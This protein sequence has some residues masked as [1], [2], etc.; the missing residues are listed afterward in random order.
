MNLILAAVLATTLHYDLDATFVRDEGRFTNHLTITFPAGT[1]TTPLLLGGAYEVTL[2]DALNGSVDIAP[3]D[4]PWRGLQ[5]IAITPRDPA[6]AVKLHLRYGGKLGPSGTPPLNTISHDL[7]ELN[8]DSMWIPVAEGF[9]TRFT[10]DANLRGIPRQLI[11]VAP[12]RVTQTRDRITIRRDVSDFDVSF[13]AMRGMRRTAANGFELYAL[14]LDSDV[15]GDLVKLYRQHGAA[16]LRF[17]ES[18][19]GAMPG[20][21]A[22]VV[23]VRRERKSGY[24]RRG[25]IVVTEVPRPGG[26]AGNAKFIAHEFAHAWWSPVD[27]NT[28]HRWLQESLAEYVALRYIEQSLG[29]PALESL[30]VAKRETAKTATPL[31][32]RGART[33]RE[34]YDKGPL[35]LMELEQRIGRASLDR[36]LRNLAPHPPSVTEEFMTELARVAGEEHAR[37]FES[38]LRAD[39]AP[40]PP[41]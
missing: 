7:V 23:V 2:A 40:R 17:L 11:A 25:Y 41:S 5:R 36:V 34:L 19:F 30:L 37:W 26:D 4:K 18:W 29:A 22:R 10:L 20:R 39:D 3:T 9:M 33:E 31:L 13:V 21:P 38:R 27:P 32:G 1:A 28:E 8:L 14:D 35:L 15:D 12:G 6:R 16:S 24:S